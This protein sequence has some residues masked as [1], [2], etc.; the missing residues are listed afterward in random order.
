[1]I[2]Y[3]HLDH[4]AVRFTDNEAWQFINGEWKEINSADARHKA[5]LLSEDVFNKM[6]ADVPALPAAAFKT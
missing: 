2:K 6:F 1:M 4:E 3:A 5:T